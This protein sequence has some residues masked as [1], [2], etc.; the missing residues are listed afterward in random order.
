MS[1]VITC[2][3]AKK[4]EFSYDIS[5]YR[6]EFSTVVTVYLCI[7]IIVEKKM[8]AVIC[9]QYNRIWFTIILYDNVTIALN[10]IAAKQKTIDSLKEKNR[11]FQ[12]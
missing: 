1:L 3:P 12:K 8:R 11:C 2:V 6:H 5:T 9:V 4:N 10:C 7:S